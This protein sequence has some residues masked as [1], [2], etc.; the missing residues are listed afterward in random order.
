MQHLIDISKMKDGN[1][2]QKGIFDES[3][4]VGLRY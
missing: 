4:D 3:L 2:S 1:N